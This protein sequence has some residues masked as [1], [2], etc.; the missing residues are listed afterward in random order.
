MSAHLQ[1]DVD[2]LK[3]QILALS[4]EVES[5]VRTAVRAIEDRRSHELIESYRQSIE[6]GS[7]HMPPLGCEG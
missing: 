6:V 4:A 7:A 1:R 5:E 2:K 3:Q